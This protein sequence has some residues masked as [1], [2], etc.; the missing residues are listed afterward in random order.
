MLD[1]LSI[2]PDEF[3]FLKNH[4]ISKV[5]SSSL[6]AYL[7]M[8]GWLC[9]FL[10]YEE[11]KATGTLLRSSQNPRT[12]YQGKRFFSSSRTYN[13]LYANNEGKLSEIVGFSTQWSQD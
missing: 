13:Q 6:V 1:Q 3:L 11:G 4:P 2:W 12:R 7:Q 5:C 10:F 8:E 9:G